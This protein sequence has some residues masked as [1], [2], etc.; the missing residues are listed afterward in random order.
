M[1]PAP[2]PE[3]AM[4]HAIC[5]ERGHDPDQKLPGTN[6]GGATYAQFHGPRVSLFLGALK[7]V[8][9]ELRRIGEGA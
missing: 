6:H 7:A 8:G 3:A 1:T 4:L 5:V 9:Y 2:T